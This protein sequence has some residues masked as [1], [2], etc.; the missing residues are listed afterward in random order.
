MRLIF[1]K[2]IAACF[3]VATISC[4]KSKNKTEVVE[5]Q[6]KKPNIIF[7]MADDLGYADI[8]PYGQKLINTPNLEQM[9]KEGMLFT[10]FYAGTAVCAPSRASLMTG[11]HTGLTDVRGNR[12]NGYRNGQMPLSANTETIATVLKKAGYHTAIV[13]KWGLG[14]P[15]TTGEP[16]KQGFDYYYG[17]TDQI[18]AHNS[19]PEYLWSNGEKEMLNNKVNYLDSLQWHEGLGSFSTEKNTY[20]Q[21]LFMDY[22]LKFIKENSNKENP[23]FLYL[24]ITIPHDN[25]EETGDNIFEVPNQGRYKDFDWSKNEKDYA[26]MITYM[27][28]GIGSILELLK[29]LNI[30]DDTLIIFTSDNGPMRD[31]PVTDFFDSNGELRGGKRDLYEGGIRVPFIARWK[32][33]IPEGS[34]TSY[35]AA[36]WDI[37]PTFA[38]IAN[39]KAQQSNGNSFLPT[40]KG[41][42]QNNVHPL[43]FEI[44]RSNTFS[45]ALRRADYKL[46]KN[47]FSKDSIITEL[48]DLKND[49][50]ESNNIADANHNIVK[51]LDSLISTMRV[52]SKFFQLPHEQ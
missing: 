17:Y 34:S 47:I 4:V 50:G 5:N 14:N 19:Y 35:Q 36:F 48:Y 10:Q 16:T 40:L 9:S 38:S 11:K 22:S 43:Y 13:G 42:T 2:C 31:M 23:F 28:T 32:G 51:E 46:V 30:D 44:H 1:F 37:L 7:I 24:S 26:S 12:Q 33:T 25:S 21:D 18:L 8:S 41:V 27:D 49:I 45:Q 6:P 39:S 52:P 29:T 15:G 3:L 20:S